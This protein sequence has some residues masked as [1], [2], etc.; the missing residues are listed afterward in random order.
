MIGKMESLIMSS[1]GNRNKTLTRHPKKKQCR[2]LS[3]VVA[4]SCD[5]EAM[6]PLVFQQTQCISVLIFQN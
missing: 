6:M 2:G 5:A 3:K 1:G 4:Q